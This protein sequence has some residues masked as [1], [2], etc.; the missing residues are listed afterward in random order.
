LRLAATAFRAISLVSPMV[1]LLVSPSGK[2]LETLVYV[3][4]FRLQPKLRFNENILEEREQVE[5]TNVVDGGRCMV[6]GK[7][8]E[9]EAS[10]EPSRGTNLEGKGKNQK[11]SSNNNLQPCSC[12]VTIL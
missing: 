6:L 1:T 9:L 7:A 12:D 5:A 4:L 3:P 8:A 10:L 11:V 2:Y